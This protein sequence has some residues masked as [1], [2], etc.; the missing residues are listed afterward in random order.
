M[1]QSAVQTT[2]AQGVLAGLLA[3]TAGYVD[4]YALLNYDVF[5]SFMSGNTTEAG[6]HAGLGRLSDAV[7]HGLPIPLF[8][9]GVFLGT[10]LLHA[11]QR[12]PMRWVCGL[13]AALLIASLC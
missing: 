8:V 5:A 6:L 10:F 13:V 3:L 7:Y 1:P 11:T 9:M 12:H 2:R 4:A